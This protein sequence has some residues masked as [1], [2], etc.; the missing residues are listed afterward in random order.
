MGQTSLDRRRFLQF[1]AAGAAA[2]SVLPTAVGAD[3]KKA[4]PWGG[5]TLGIQ[6]YTF[7]EFSLEQALKK[8]QALGLK[9]AEFYSGH[10]PITDDAGKIKTVLS[11]CKEY[12]ITPVAFGVE[13]FSKD[14]DKNK[15]KFEFAKALGIKTLSADPDP[16][17]FDSLDKLVEE[18][19][20]S[21]GIHP[22]GPKH[23]YPNAEVILKTVKDHNPLIG[24]TLDTGHLIK[25]DGLDPAEEV[26][27]MGER[28]FG[29]HLKDH[30]VRA[31]HDV[32]F[33]K[34]RLDV[35]EILKALKEVKFKGYIA[36]EY[37]HNAKEPS[38]DVQA[39]LEV[40]KGA[41]KKLT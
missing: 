36:V 4:D 24:T 26:R 39:C 40:F 28:N 1:A 12:D 9:Y 2:F 21:I 10:I 17:S 14:H 20:I 41:V 15:A 25:V 38:E 33:G 34:G 22:H 11:L 3:D 7:R 23:R 18:Y 30:D 27:K 32:V 29:M 5:F 31:G 16:D 35:A 37:E 13:N 8:T 6:S 19:K